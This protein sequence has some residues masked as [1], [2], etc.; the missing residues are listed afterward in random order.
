MENY[1]QNKIGP[2]EV[3]NNVFQIIKR[4]SQVPKTHQ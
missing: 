3:S 2:R 4:T 1:F